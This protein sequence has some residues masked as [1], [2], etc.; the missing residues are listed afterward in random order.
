MKRGDIWLVGLGYV[1]KVRPIMILSVEPRTEDRALV[2][3]VIR[4]TRVRM[5]C[6]WQIS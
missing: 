1:G 3:Y 2:T 5:R 6:R 4:T